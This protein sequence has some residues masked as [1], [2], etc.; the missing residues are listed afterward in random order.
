MQPFER[1][2]QGKLIL[3]YTAEGSDIFA[4]SLWKAIWYY[5]SQ[6]KICKSYDVEISPIEICPR[7]TLEH[8]LKG[9][10]SGC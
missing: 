9:V 10:H 1:R 2:K 4:S 8:L 3:S 6:F 7:D 5:L